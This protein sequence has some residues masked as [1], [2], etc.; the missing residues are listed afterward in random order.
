MRSAASVL[1]VLALLLPACASTT[2]SPTARATAPPGL[3]GIAAS[4][5]DLVENSNA[6]TCAFNAVLL[7]SAPTLADLTRGSAA[8]AAT[9][10]TLIGGLRAIPW[11]GEL[12]QDA[13]DLIDA[14][15]TNETLTRAMADS[16]TLDSFIAADNALIAAN[17]ASSAAATQLR[18]DL[19]LPRVNNPC[20]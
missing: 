18:N 6:A 7:Q 10:A 16:D 13:N 1:L 3:E 17:G 15:V 19:G 9:L 20:T 14:L 8:Y 4:Y 11:P 2:P 5:L 12:T